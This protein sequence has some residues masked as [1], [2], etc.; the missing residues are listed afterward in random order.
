[1]RTPTNNTNGRRQSR[2]LYNGSQACESLERRALFTAVPV[3]P[4]VDARFNFETA[5]QNLQ[6]RFNQDVSATLD[7]GDLVLLCDR[8]RNVV[9]GAALELKYD[10]D[11]NT[12]TFTFPFMQNG[13]LPDGNWSA[14]LSGSGIF[15][16]APPTLPVPKSADLPGPS[17]VIEGLGGIGGALRDPRLINLPGPS[18]EIDGLGG[19]RG[20]LADPRL[21]NLPGPSP[22]ID[23]VGAGTIGNG[24]S[25]KTIHDLTQGLGGA[26]GSLGDLRLITLPDGS[27]VTEGNGSGTNPNG[28]FVFLFSFLNGDA[29]QDG[30]VDAADF[31]VVVRNMGNYHATFSQGDFDYNG[32]VDQADA[33]IVIRQFGINL[34]SP[35]TTAQTAGKQGPFSTDPVPVDSLHDWLVHRD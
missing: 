1:M 19:I 3:S 29:T 7:T 15:D 31:A 20:A 8:M 35:A 9:T 5:P 22:E 21:I 6:I 24:G 34:D 30:M 33:N 27:P 2:S 10:R 23:G 11:T 17:P 18:P 14:T 16:P 28:D 26:R 13:V 4:V 12:A 25:P 32:I